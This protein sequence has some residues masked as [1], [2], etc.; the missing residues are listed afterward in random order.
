MANTTINMS[1]VVENA[2]IRAKAE[3]EL[4]EFDESLDELELSENEKLTLA[5][6]IQNAFG[7]HLNILIAGATGCGKSTTILALFDEDK[8]SE[9]DRQSLRIKDSGQPQT[10]QIRPYKVGENLTLWDSPGLGDGEKDEQHIDKIRAKCREK[11]KKG[12][13][14][15]D[16]GL[17]I[18]GGVVARDLESTYKVIDVLVDELCVGE[19][20][21]ARVVVAINKCDLSGNPEAKFDYDKNEPSDTLKDELETKMQDFKERF[22]QNK[23]GKFSIMYY[24]A[25]YLDEKSGV[26]KEP[27]NLAKLL[28]FITKS[29]P[30]KK[31]FLF[32]DK[33][34]KEKGNFRANEKGKEWQKDTEKSWLDSVMETITDGIKVVGDTIEKVREVGKKVL[35]AAPTLITIFTTAR[36]IFTKGLKFFK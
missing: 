7:K 29:A 30:S 36:D 18:I 4:K 15:I 35:K 10:M 13:G 27:Y 11:D 32:S 23:R 26:K 5:K 33:I 14:L 3:A 28:N 2:A 24:A 16:L 21:E 22:A 31:R 17:V 8:M 9:E 19:K 1:K 25:G 34:S 6:N 20:S 12:D